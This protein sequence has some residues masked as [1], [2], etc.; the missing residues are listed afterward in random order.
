[1]AMIN[2]QKDHNKTHLNATI[3]YIISNLNRFHFLKTL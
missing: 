1:M 3:A 2:G